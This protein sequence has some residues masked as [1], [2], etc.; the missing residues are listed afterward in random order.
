MQVLNDAIDNKIVRTINQNFIIRYFYNAEPN[1]TYLIGAGRYD[2]LVGEIL[3]IK[4][5]N[6]VLST[7]LSVTTFKLRR[8]LTINFCCK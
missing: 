1:K 8:G 5:F 3:Q 7:S 6:K 4:H 2:T